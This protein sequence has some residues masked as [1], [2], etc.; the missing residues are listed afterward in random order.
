MKSIT[1]LVGLAL[2]PIFFSAQAQISQTQIPLAQIVTNQG[3]M[4]RRARFPEQDV[5]NLDSDIRAQLRVLEKVQAEFGSAIDDT[6]ARID[7]GEDI[8]FSQSFLESANTTIESIQGNIRIADEMF[9]NILCSVPEGCHVM[10]K[11]L[12]NDTIAGMQEVMESM[13]KFNDIHDKL[14]SREMTVVVI[15]RERA[16]AALASERIIVPRGLSRE[17]KRQLILSHAS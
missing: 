2:A 5:I 15:D 3:S 12:K 17:E 6:L 16:A 13:K 14:Q 11:R 1:T 10:V 4:D 8:N 9:D 7:R